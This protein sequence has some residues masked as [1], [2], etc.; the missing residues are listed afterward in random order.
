[1][2]S[3]AARRRLFWWAVQR[4][5]E[6]GMLRA[7]TVAGTLIAGL[8]LGVAPA[9]ATFHLEM[10]NEVMLS[11]AAGDP[12]VQF[13]ELLDHGGS[14]EAFT[15]V[16]APYK[17]VVY[18]GAANKL[19]EHML[20]PTGLR[21]AAAADAPYLLSTA[22]ADAAL[23]VQGDERLDVGLPAAAGQ[24]CFEASP[25]PHAF[26]CLTWGTVTKAVATNSMGT[27]S[28][29]GPVP[30]AGESDQRQADGT[31][32]AAAPTPKAANRAGA[33]A[34]AGAPAFAGVV[35]AAHR[36]KVDRHGRAGVR[37][38]CP[39]GTDGSCRGRLTLTAT[40]GA[41]TLG[42]ASYTIDAA[43]GATVRVKLTAAARQRLRH[44]HQL[45]CR[46]RAVARDAAGTS[47]T[48]GARITLVG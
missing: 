5:W 8:S 13:V 47:K 12:A 4:E 15:P 45:A 24:A 6:V 27:G 37:L 48:T 19:G 23:G 3:F 25:S 7:A 38:R 21:M 42:H 2:G 28:A 22:A 16:F 18:D 14:E 9:A 30:P 44:H 29:N 39:A 1:M 31:V 10:V 32:V 43:S 11:S 20:D 36:A 41:V 17:L 35:F 40:T 26:N 33:P 34:G 46:G